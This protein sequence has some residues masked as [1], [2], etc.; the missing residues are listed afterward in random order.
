MNRKLRNSELK[1]LGP[2]GQTDMTQTDSTGKAASRFRGVKQRQTANRGHGVS[3]TT[4]ARCPIQ[5]TH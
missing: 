4:T 5:G 3:L 1:C 2:G